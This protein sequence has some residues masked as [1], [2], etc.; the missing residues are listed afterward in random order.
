[1]LIETYIHDPAERYRLF[2]AIDSMPFVKKKADW[3]FQWTYDRRASF[4]ERL[5]AFVAVEGI[6]FS[7]SFAAIFYFKKR[8]LLPGLSFLNALI[9]RDEISFLFRHFIKKLFCNPF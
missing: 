6:F 9:A 5:V 1:M 8:G 3:A 7:G 4:G 2:R